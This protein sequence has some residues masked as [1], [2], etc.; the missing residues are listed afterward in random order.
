MYMICCLADFAIFPIMFTVVQF[1]ENE[2]AND[3]FRQWVPIT[4]QGGGLFHVSM[5]AVLGV[6]A[7]G[8][9]QEKLAGQSTGLPT[10]DLGAVNA[11]TPIQPTTPSVSAPVGNTSNSTAS[12]AFSAPGFGAV[13][14]QASSGA[15]GSFGSAPA[16]PAFAAVTT[17]AS[18]KPGPA[19]PDHPEI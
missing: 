14:S 7:Y 17:S 3:A 12:P 4:L 15:P 6:S 9:T 2:A 16:T 11:T 10:P 8:R 13:P 1:W 5:C 19:Q 18:G